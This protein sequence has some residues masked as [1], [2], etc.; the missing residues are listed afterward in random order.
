MSRLR[1]LLGAGLRQN[2]GLALLK[3]KVF[4]QKKDLWLVL[5]FAIAGL[6]MLPLL[7]FYVAGL[8]RLFAILRPMGQEAALLTLAILAGQ[9]LI[10]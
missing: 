4:K 5:L 1:A 10:L 9:I 7:V 2:F 6:G 8:G 3:Y